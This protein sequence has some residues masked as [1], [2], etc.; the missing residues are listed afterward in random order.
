MRISDEHLAIEVKHV[1]GPKYSKYFENGVKEFGFEFYRDL[2]LDLAEAR[3]LV[4][5][6]RKRRA[7]RRA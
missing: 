3:G 7:G 4:R 2:V 6:G 5:E 1:T